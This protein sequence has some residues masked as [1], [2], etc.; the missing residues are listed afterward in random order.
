MKLNDY[1]VYKTESNDLWFCRCVQAHPIQMEVING[2][3]PFELAKVNGVLEA[4][5]V[6]GEAGKFAGDLA[7]TLTVYCDD[8]ILEDF[9][10]AYIPA[11][12]YARLKNKEKPYGECWGMIYKLST[13]SFMRS[14]SYV[15]QEEMR[16]QKRISCPGCEKCKDLSSTIPDFLASGDPPHINDPR[17]GEWYY[18]AVTNETRDWE[19]GQVDGW[20]LEF[21][22]VGGK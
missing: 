22:R 8:L 9:G 3:W 5:Y 15:Y 13:S 16:P 21:K 20:E 6:Q 4:R 1:I 19:T 2:R 12:T 18:L 17:D 14:G 11:L 10:D 7:G